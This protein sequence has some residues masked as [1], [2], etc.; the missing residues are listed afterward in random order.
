MGDDTLPA[1]RKSLEPPTAMI[2][3]TRKRIAQHAVHPLPCGKHLR[4]FK[5][6]RHRAGLVENL[7]RAHGDAEIARVERKRIHTRNQFTLRHDPGATVGE[8]A[9]DPLE[10]FNRPATAAQH[11]CRQ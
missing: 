2:P 4:T 5:R 6:R 8:F 11:D 10:D 7:S 9:F 1:L 3:L